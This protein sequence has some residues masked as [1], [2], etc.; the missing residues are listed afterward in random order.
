MPTPPFGADTNDRAAADR[1]EC[2]LFD[3]LAQIAGPCRAERVADR[4]TTAVRIDTFTRKGAKVTLNCVT[5][6][7]KR[8][9][10]QRVDVAKY[11]CR[12]RLMNLL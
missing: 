3:R 1:H 4:D 10:L 6:G 12:E 9:A 11:L 7:L 8:W 2:K 5:H